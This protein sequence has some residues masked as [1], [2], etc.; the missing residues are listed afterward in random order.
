M[1]GIQTLPLP[2]FAPDAL[3]RPYDYGYLGGQPLPDSSGAVQQ[4]NLPTP[5]EVGQTIQQYA[6]PIQMPDIV[7]AQYGKGN[8]V[9]VGALLKIANGQDGG[10]TGVDQARALK[11]LNEW[12]Y[13]SDASAWT[14]EQWQ[15]ALDQA[16]TEPN[17][18]TALG[19]G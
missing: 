13:P 4:V 12:G 14:A 17:L 18:L 11:L 10:L 15:A 8:K 19:Y 5:G 7:Q 6:P 1:A 9:I 16:A 2:N 3:P